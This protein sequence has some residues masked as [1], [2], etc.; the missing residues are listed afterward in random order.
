MRLDDDREI[1]ATRAFFAERGL[2]PDIPE[3]FGHD[4][5]AAGLLRERILAGAGP[6]RRLARRRRPA[7]LLVAVVLL[8]LLGTGASTLL[9]DR[10]AAAATTPVMLAYGVADLASA[11]SAPPAAPALEAAARSAASLSAARKNGSVQYLARYGWLAGQDVDESDTLAVALYP[12]LTQWWMAADG[13]VRLDESRGAP[14]DFQGRL[15]APRQG[16]PDAVTTDTVPAGSLDPGLAERLSTVPARLRTQLVDT[17]E[18]LPCDQDDHWR[19]VCL[20]QAVQTL[21][22]QY[23]LPPALVAALWEVLA[24]EPALRSLGETTDRLG[25]AAVAIALPP[26]PDEE[27]PQV[28]A[29]LISSVTGAYLGTE[30]IMLH[31]AALGIDG[32]TVLGFSELSTAAWVAAPGDRP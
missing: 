20:V 26:A 17:Q 11:A 10:P 12:T 28:T 25:R 24:D 6:A 27:S 16:A 30:T 9:H 5:R 4:E 13:S 21:Y 15:T 7:R 19:A 22:D 23:V 32:P 29:L 1:E 14:L 31:D 18:G 8:A 2:L 3:R